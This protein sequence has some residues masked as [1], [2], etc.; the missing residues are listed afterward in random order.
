MVLSIVAGAGVVL[1]F[2]FDDARGDYE[3]CWNVCKNQLYSQCL[4]ERPGGANNL[5]T[6]ESCNAGLDTCKTMCN[7]GQSPTFDNDPS[8]D[9]YGTW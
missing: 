7:N 9:N 8:A 5:A 4:S 1:T 2:V 3:T 6:K